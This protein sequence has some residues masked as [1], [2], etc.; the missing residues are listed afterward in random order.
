MSLPLVSSWNK[1][2]IGAFER[3][4]S[5]VVTLAVGASFVDIGG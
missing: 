2:K 1:T 3:S 5:S 4:D